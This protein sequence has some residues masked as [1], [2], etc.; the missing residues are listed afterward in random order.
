MKD[1]DLFLCV[2]KGNR[3][4]MENSINLYILKEIKY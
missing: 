4:L 3:R 2:K 1:I